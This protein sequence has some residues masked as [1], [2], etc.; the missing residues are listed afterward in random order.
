MGGTTPVSGGPASGIGPMAASRGGG[1]GGGIGT[2]ISASMPASSPASSPPV[3]VSAGGGIGPMIA[4]MPESVAGLPS[5][6]HAPRVAEAITAPA[7]RRCATRTSAGPAGRGE[8]SSSFE[9]IASV[10]A[11]GPGGVD[12]G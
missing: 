3:P 9:A 11:A 5:P 7:A 1:I 4:S 6:P 2:T 10:Y 8:R 12:G